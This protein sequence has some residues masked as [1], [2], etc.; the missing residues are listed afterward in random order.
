MQTV[1]PPTR[2][3]LLRDTQW[4][5][6]F[7]AVTR[8]QIPSGLPFSMTCLKQVEATFKE[9]RAH[10]LNCALF[11]QTGVSRLPTIA[12]GAQ[13]KAAGLALWHWSEA[14]GL[15]T[16]RVSHLPQGTPACSGKNYSTT[17][18][19]PRQWWADRGGSTGRGRIAMR[20]GRLNGR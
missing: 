5:S 18:F 19:S 4:T 15:P 16:C 14:P 8:V 12:Q 11:W 7:T 3:Q 20:D 2:L 17:T 1:M 10:S 6:P 13:R 9:Q